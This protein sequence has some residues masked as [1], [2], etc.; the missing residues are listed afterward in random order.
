MN[1]ITRDKR[2]TEISTPQYYR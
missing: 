2:G 1:N